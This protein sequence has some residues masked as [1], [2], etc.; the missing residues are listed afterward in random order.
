MKCCQ[1]LVE[2]DNDGNIKR[3]SMSFH[4][5]GVYEAMEIEASS[6]VRVVKSA[7]LPAPGFWK[8][9]NTFSYTEEVGGGLVTV[10]YPYVSWLDTQK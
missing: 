2:N 10:D 9:A 8:T 6:D 3:A 4:A 5:Y 1:F 7:I